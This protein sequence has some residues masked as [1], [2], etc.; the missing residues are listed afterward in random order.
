VSEDQKPAGP[1]ASS[2]TPAE[3]PQQPA[4]VNPQVDVDLQTF[5]RTIEPTNQ[6]LQTTEKKTATGR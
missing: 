1:V 6:R 5:K 3:T 2:N 4:Q